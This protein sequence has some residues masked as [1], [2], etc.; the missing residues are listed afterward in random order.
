M[1]RRNDQSDVDPLTTRQKEVL[2]GSLL[3]D[4][5]LTL[6]SGRRNPY[7]QIQRQ[8]ADR[9]Y[10]EWQ[11]ACFANLCK[12]GIGEG[13]TLDQRT[14]ETYYYAYF[15]T[16]SLPELLPIYRQ[17]YPN[18]IKVVPHNIQLSPLTVAIWFADDGR[19]NRVVKSELTLSL[20]TDGFSQDDVCFLVSLLKDTLHEDFKAY[21]KGAS[22]KGQPQYIINASSTGTY[23]LIKYMEADFSQLSMSRKNVWTNV[24][25]DFPAQSK[26]STRYYQIADL[27]L[28]QDSIT[29]KDIISLNIYS[30]RP[31]INDVL[32]NF[33]KSGYLT[34]ARH[35]QRDEY[36]YTPTPLGFRYF[37]A[38]QFEKPLLLDKGSRS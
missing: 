21:R 30:G 8:L 5:G 9:K 35:H 3:G 28:E 14:G 10:L 23:A 34:R 2:V 7:M 26:R 4:A 17:W 20:A 25:L 13:S 24:C 27:I 31:A 22:K 33:F 32:F 19:I 36:R 1:S 29:T 18:G 11:Y 12:S 37:S 15:L 6:R 38:L 16:R